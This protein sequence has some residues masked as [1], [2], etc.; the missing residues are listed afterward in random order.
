MIIGHDMAGHEMAR[1]EEAQEEDGIPATH[2]KTRVFLSYARADRPRA[3]ALALALQ[4]AGLDVWWDAEIMGGDAFANSIET[5]LD[6]ADAIVVAWSQASV[7][8][9]W[10]RDEA[11][12]GR[13]RKRLVPVSLDGIVPPL[14]FRQYH[15]VDLSGWHGAAQAPEIAAVAAAVRA[16]AGE[17]TGKDTVSAPPY[18]QL[19]STIWSRRNL[20]FAAGIAGAVGATGAGLTL[21][22]GLSAPP[23]DD[24]SV[25]VLP[26]ANF[27]GDPQ[28]Q[29][30]SDGLSDELRAALARDGRLKVMGQVSTSAAGSDIKTVSRALGVAFLLS[31]GVQRAGDSIQISAHL[32]DGHSGT[33]AWAQTFQGSVEQIFAIEAEI[34]AVA[35]AA[36]TQQVDND[37]KPEPVKPTDDKF[38]GGT[39]NV[40]AYQ[41]Y[42]KGRELYQRGH[43]ETSDRAALTQFEA[44]VTA[45]P[46]FAV[47]RSA[48]ARSLATI[49]SVYALPAQARTLYDA[50]FADAAKA[51][52]DAPESAYIQSTLGKVLAEGRLDVRAARAPFEKALA[53][54]GNDSAALTQA[55]RFAAQTGQG[56][57]ALNAIAHAKEID[58]LNPLVHRMAGLIRIALRQ[59]DQA[60]PPLRQSLALQPDDDVS[61]A[62]IGLVYLQQNRLDD[63]RRALQAEPDETQRFTGLAIVERRA[64]H[65]AAAE[66]A[67]DALVKGQ[68]DGALYQQAQVKAQWGDADGAM[69][70]LQRAKT[71]GDAG[72]LDMKTDV[73]LDPLRPDP[74]F[75]SLLADIGFS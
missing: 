40:D 36:L 21:W 32:N 37:G 69:G 5:A 28:Q 64:G 42:L 55:A 17:K 41:A 61:N 35:L 72:L 65:A 39:T 73:L 62:A 27:T 38:Y 14:G 49:A 60:L 56:D 47:A 74:R 44:A 71:T 7:V 25:A 6:A 29:Y 9:D 3:A 26:F 53:L 54:G 75:S 59:F 11:G 15:A 1:D 67:F 8:S 24:H 23:V 57:Q 58:P 16:R 18:P 45:D 13:D 4:A 2:G 34:A 52:A 10:V 22:R 46:A 31:G 66:A 68:G 50:A 19:Q 12:H 20:M 33:E 70:L 30:F 51:A 63:A 48:H 43:G